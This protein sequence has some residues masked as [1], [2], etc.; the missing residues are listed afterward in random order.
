MPVTSP[1]FI[2]FSSTI[3]L[4]AGDND[5]FMLP[6]WFLAT[7]FVKIN[8]CFS[9]VKINGC[10]S[11]ALIFSLSNTFNS[12]FFSESKSITLFVFSSSILGVSFFISDI[13]SFSSTLSK[14]APSSA[15]TFT[16]SPFL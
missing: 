5:L 2:L 7:S 3:F 12:V 16:M 1:A 6:F 4:T 14:I 13:F 10:F 15:P 11:D 8:G 9:D